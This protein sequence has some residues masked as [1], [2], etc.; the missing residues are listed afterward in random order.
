MDASG[1]SVK[2]LEEGFN[3][4][5]QSGDPAAISDINLVL[6]DLGIASQDTVFAI[7]DLATKMRDLLVEGGMDPAK[8]DPMIE[9]LKQLANSSVNASNG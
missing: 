7:V 5:E 3:R 4:L 8:V 1:E 9:K 6:K 2:R